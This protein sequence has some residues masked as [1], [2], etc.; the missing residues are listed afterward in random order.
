M[1]FTV[2]VD[3]CLYTEVVVG[4]MIERR[5]VHPYTFISGWLAHLIV[6]SWGSCFAY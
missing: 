6:G 3:L 4:P 1:S 5:P 2:F